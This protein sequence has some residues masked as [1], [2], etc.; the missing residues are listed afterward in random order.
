MRERVPDFVRLLE[1]E[2]VE[3]R[4]AAGDNI[5]MVYAAN[6][7]TLTSPAPRPMVAAPILEDLVLDGPGVRRDSLASVTTQ[8]TQTTVQWEAESKRGPVDVNLLIAKFSEL[9]TDGSKRHARK[10]RRAQRSTFRD[11][12]K[13]MQAG[14]LPSEQ[15]VI[16]TE[17]HEFTGWRVLRQLD[18]FRKVLA[19]GMQPHLLR[20]E[21]L[22]HVFHIE[23]PKEDL[24][25][26]ERRANRQDQMAHSRLREKEEQEKHRQRRRDK[27]HATA[28]DE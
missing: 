25:A 20:N 2:A 15:L 13:T 17:K 21:L 10:D 22:A 28:A 1:S 7:E 8:S 5:A 24:T 23:P 4:Q 26:A 16:G 6:L 9:S 11:I 19:S 14:D 3:V 12:L 27:R 18:A